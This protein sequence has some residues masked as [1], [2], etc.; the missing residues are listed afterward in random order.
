MRSTVSTFA[1]T[2][3]WLGFVVAIFTPVTLALWACVCALDAAK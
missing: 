3:F 1:R 2:V